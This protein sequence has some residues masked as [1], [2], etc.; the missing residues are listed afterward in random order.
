M[1]LDHLVIN[2]GL[3]MDAAA[4]LFTSLGF[5]LTPRG[6]HSLGS[7]NHLMMDPVSYLELVGVPATGKQRQEVLDSPLGL[8]GLVFRSDDAEATFARLSTAGFAPQEPILLERPVTIDGGARV[9]R[10]HNVRMTTAE[11]PAGRVYFCQH[12]T[13][14]LV[15]RK[16][17]LSHPNGFCGIA[18]MTVL[19]P[20]PEEEAARYAALTEGSAQ[21]DGNGWRI[22]EGGFV[23]RIARGP[24]AFA[25]ATL[26]F[27]DLVQI[28]GLA[29]ASSGVEWQSQ[30]D[31]AGVLTIPSLAVT[32]HCRAA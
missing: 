23:L 12:L 2:T 26:V 7:I 19:S 15:W 8:S 17:W 4:A 25:S 16:E 11:F 18:G 21:C 31:R 10:F 20:D 14:D 27:E 28:A 13:P 6:H 29:K 22:D 24:S 3:G 32:L 30:G 5:Q 9:A 1:Q